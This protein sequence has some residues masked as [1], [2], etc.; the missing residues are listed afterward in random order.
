MGARRR[1]QNISGSSR[2]RSRFSRN[3]NNYTCRWGI[4]A[5]TQIHFFDGDWVI[6]CFGCVSLCS[7]LYNMFITCFHKTSVNA[8]PL[9]PLFFEEIAAHKEIYV[10]FSF[11]CLRL[12]FFL[13][14]I[15]LLNFGYPLPTPILDRFGCHLW[16]N[17]PALS[18]ARAELLQRLRKKLLKKLLKKLA[19]N[20]QET[21]KKCKE[22]AEN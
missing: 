17:F 9:S 7:V 15:F 2:L 20:Y 13:F 10:L 8:Q 1:K 3:H 19:E 21:Y 4:V 5:F 18:A 16:I 22:L 14:F 11:L 6:S 12:H